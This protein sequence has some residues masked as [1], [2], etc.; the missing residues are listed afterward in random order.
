MLPA[1]QDEDVA[2]DPSG[3]PRAPFDI[4]IK[5]AIITLGSKKGSNRKDIIEKIM[6]VNDIKYERCKKAVGRMLKVMVAAGLIYK[7]KPGFFK[8]TAKG[9]ALKLKKKRKKRKRKRRRRKRKAKKKRRKAKKRR[10]RKKKRRRR[11]RKRK[12]KKGRGRKPKIRKCGKLILV[13]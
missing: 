1:S 13:K 2:P 7:N 3:R 9:R 6:S 11:R 8:I 4:L 12:G 5:R 10:K